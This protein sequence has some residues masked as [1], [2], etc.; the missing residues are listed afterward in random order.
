MGKQ[1][2]NSKLVANSKFFGTKQE[3]GEKPADKI[4]LEKI[5]QYNRFDMAKFAKTLEQLG[6]KLSMSLN[7]NKPVEVCIQANGE[8][9]EVIIDKSMLLTVIHN[10]NVERMKAMENNSKYNKEVSDLI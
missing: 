10:G 1:N 6:I 4:V 8:I 2:N 5:K 3:V 7:E 9:S